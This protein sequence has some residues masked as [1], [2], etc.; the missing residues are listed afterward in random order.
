MFTGPF[1]MLTVFLMPLSVGC[2]LEWRYY[3]IVNTLQRVSF[4]ASLM[5][6]CVVLAF[7]AVTGAVVG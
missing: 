7:V 5:V 3:E 1:L 2:L 6:A 4:A